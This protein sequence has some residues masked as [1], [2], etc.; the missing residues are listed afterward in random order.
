MKW[1]K[2]ITDSTKVE[3]SPPKR[4][5]PFPYESPETVFLQH[6]QR[7]T[8]HGSDEDDLRI[9]FEDLAQGRLG[10]QPLLTH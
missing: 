6:S 9:F 8:S 2:A 10:A 7:R 1:T 3:K 5:L 4:A